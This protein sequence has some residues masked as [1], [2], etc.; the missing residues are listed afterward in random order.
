MSPRRPKMHSRRPKM[1]SRRP[2]RTPRDFHDGSRGPPLSFQNGPRGHQEQLPEGPMRL[3]LR[4]PDTQHATRSV[5]TRSS[6]R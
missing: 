5:L 6:A 3:K 4:R 2:K 1:A